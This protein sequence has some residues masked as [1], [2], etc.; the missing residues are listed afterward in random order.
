MPRGL[1]P[2]L[3]FSAIPIGFRQLDPPQSRNPGPGDRFESTTLHKSTVVLQ[4]V[5]QHLA[6]P[7]LV[8][9][10][11]VSD[12]ALRTE[13][14]QIQ[15][16]LSYTIRSSGVSLLEVRHVLLYD[17][18]SRGQILRA[19]EGAGGGGGKGK[20][21]YQGIIGASQSKLYCISSL[22]FKRT[23]TIRTHK[24]LHEDADSIQLMW[25]MQLKAKVLPPPA[26][27]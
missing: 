3:F 7:A 16:V 22:Q 23:C 20:R 19:G 9:N 15:C 13:Y 25:H 18:H 24:R 6:Q 1:L 5:D 21:V 4:Y 26:S 27:V 12:V 11:F 8:L 14:C 17:I 2:S 10:V